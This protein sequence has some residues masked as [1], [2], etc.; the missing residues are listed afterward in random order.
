V[1]TAHMTGMATVDDRMLIML[2]MAR[3]LTDEDLV[4]QERLV[5]A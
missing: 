4:A 3:F 5:T 1:N 2:D